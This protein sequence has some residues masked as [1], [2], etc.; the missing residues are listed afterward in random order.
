[1][2]EWTSACLL[3]PSSNPKCSSAALQNQTMSLLYQR[4][5][6]R[7][8]LQLL[9]LLVP[10]S[11]SLQLRQTKVALSPCCWMLCVGQWRLQSNGCLCTLQMFGDDNIFGSG[12]ADALSCT[13]GSER[14][15]LLFFFLSSFFCQCWNHLFLFVSNVLVTRWKIIIWYQTV[16]NK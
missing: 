15:S 16:Q 5:P 2:G 13:T 14:M 6:V 7:P 10:H 1:M 8:V 9:L 4:G 11:G 12:S 3:N